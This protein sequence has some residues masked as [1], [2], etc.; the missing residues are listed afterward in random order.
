MHEIVYTSPKFGPMTVQMSDV[1]AICIFVSEARRRMARAKAYGIELRVGIPDLDMPK[2]GTADFWS[3]E[4]YPGTHGL[5]HYGVL[6]CLDYKNGSGVEVP[7][8]SHVD[9]EAGERVADPLTLNPQLGSYLWGL[10][11]MIE[12]TH[13]PVGAV[14]VFEGVVVQPN[15]QSWAGTPK[16]VRLLRSEFFAWVDRVAFPAVA[17]SRAPDAPLIAGPHCRKTFCPARGT[18]PAVLRDAMAEVLAAQPALRPAPGTAIFA[19]Y[20]GA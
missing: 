10:V 4:D 3:C 15:A 5:P 18:C 7:L 16:T 20:T 14:Q 11:R 8:V 2:G 9:N 13:L 17:A 6:S 12:G 19:P 1:R